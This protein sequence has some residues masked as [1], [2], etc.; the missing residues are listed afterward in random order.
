MNKRSKIYANIVITL[1]IMWL[2]VPLLATVVYS[3]FE[4]WTGIV[5]R[6]FTLSNYTKI[7]TDS[8]FLTAM[9]QTV[10]VCVVPIVITI[11]VILLALFTVTVYFPSW[12]NMC[13]YC[14]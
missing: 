1:V 10:L 6:G 8:A 14:A 9:Y 11:V 5:P 3:L 12:R 4:D 7:F 2:V 13:R